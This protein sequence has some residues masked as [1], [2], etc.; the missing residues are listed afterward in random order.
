MIIAAKNQLSMPLWLAVFLL[1]F[2]KPQKIET[3]FLY[4]GKT[5]TINI[6]NQSQ[7]RIQEPGRVARDRSL[8][9]LHAY[10]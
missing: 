8:H 2:Q 10:V 1:F 6:N 5:I 9:Q 3:Y 4:R 7:N